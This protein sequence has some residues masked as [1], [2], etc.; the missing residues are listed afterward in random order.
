MDRAQPDL[1]QGGAQGPTLCPRSWQSPPT[2]LKFLG[3]VALAS[4]ACQLAAVWPDQHHWAKFSPSFAELEGR[5]EVPWDE[6]PHRSDYDEYR[7]KYDLWNV[8]E[9]F[10]YE[11]EK[12]DWRSYAYGTYTVIKCNSYT[13]AIEGRGGGADDE[14]CRGRGKQCEDHFAATSTARTTTCVAL[15]CAAVV[16]LWF[17]F[18]CIRAL[19]LGRGLEASPKAIF[20]A[21]AVLAVGGVVGLAGAN[22]Y[23]ST[24]AAMDDYRTQAAHRHDWGCALSLYAGVGAMVVGAAVAALEARSNAEELRRWSCIDLKEV[25]SPDAP[26]LKKAFV[27]VG[28]LGLLCAGAHAYALFPFLKLLHWARF[29][30][31]LEMWYDLSF[32]MT[33]DLNVFEIHM[34]RG[35]HMNIGDTTYGYLEEGNWAID[36]GKSWCDT[37]IGASCN[38]HEY[39]YEIHGESC[40]CGE[41]FCSTVAIATLDAR[42][43]GWVAL[44]SAA[45]TGLGSLFAAWRASGW[46]DKAKTKV[47]A[48]FST[49]LAVGGVV[50]LASAVNYRS[51]MEA[52]R[53]ELDNSAPPETCASGCLVS[54]CAGVLAAVGAIGIVVRAIAVTKQRQASAKPSDSVET[55]PTPPPETEPEAEAEELGFMGKLA[56]YLFGEEEPAVESEGVA[57]EAEAMRE[58]EEL[59]PER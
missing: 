24:A 36:K 46:P 19:R 52:L 44:G 6:I 26:A 49:L 59:E 53:H 27:R 39:Y 28:L 35:D 21:A 13:T 56:W 2:R 29:D 40:D 8:K 14:S 18:I 11:S 16:A 41:S 42:R 43:S 15:I 31:K 48:G 23:R 20:G 22:N 33:Y 47:F 38:C 37:A 55:P 10:C 45:V 25:P 58:Q 12:S 30:L 4:T 17:L 54:L 5:G 3:V 51:T 7:L 9:K 50:G 34:N 1:Q 32:R 57:V